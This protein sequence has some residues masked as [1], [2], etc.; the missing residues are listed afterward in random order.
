MDVTGRADSAGLPCT[1]LVANH[2]QP[3]QSCGV[4]HEF[5]SSH[6]ALLPTSC[7]RSP[8]ASELS[9]RYSRSS[10]TGFLRHSR[11][12]RHGGLRS[13]HHGGVCALPLLTGNSAAAARKAIKVRTKN[14]PPQPSTTT[15]HALPPWEP[16]PTLAEGFTGRTILR[17]GAECMF[18]C[19]ERDPARSA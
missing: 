4:T 2:T 10:G 7:Y 6:Q 9:T 16:S 1:S 14:L 12:Q 15:H 18:V 17:K 13:G 19:I 3:G 11:A 8:L 5:P